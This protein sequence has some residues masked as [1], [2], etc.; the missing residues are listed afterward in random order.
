MPAE[1]LVK[2]NEP[3]TLQLIAIDF[4]HGFGLPDFG[5]RVDLVPGKV[6]ELAVTPDKAGRF[7]M[8]CD[9]FCGEGHDKMSGWLVVSE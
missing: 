3:V 6:V 4:A 5:L 8:L 1:I 7:H 9:N 2:K